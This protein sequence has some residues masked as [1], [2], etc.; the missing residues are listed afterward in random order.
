MQVEVCQ[1]LGKNKG[2]WERGVGGGGLQSSL[3]RRQRGK[4]AA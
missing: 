3:L 4:D 2:W 1:V